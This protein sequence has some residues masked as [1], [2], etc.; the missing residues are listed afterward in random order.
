MTPEGSVTRWIEQLK[1]GD[2]LA[3][4]KLWEQYFRRLVGLARKRIRG[5]RRRV[6]DEEGVALSGLWQEDIE[7]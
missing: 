5:T 3:A 7:P 1:T 6:Q 4:Q 2:P